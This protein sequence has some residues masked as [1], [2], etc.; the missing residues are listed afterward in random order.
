M[1]YSTNSK[2]I[3]IGGGVLKELH[4]FILIPDQAELGF[5]TEDEFYSNLQEIGIEQPAWQEPL[6]ILQKY[7][8]TRCLEWI[9]DCN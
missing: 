2:P 8:Q 1:V 4:W 6:S 7:D 3:D 9:P 5:E